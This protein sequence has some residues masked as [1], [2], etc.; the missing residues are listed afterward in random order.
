MNIAVIYSEYYQ[1]VWSGQKK[2]VEDF[3]LEKNLTLEYFKIPGSL[4]APFMAAKIIKQ[5]GFDGIVVLGC[6][7]EGETYHNHIIQNCAHDHL[8]RLSTD[9]LIPMGIGILTVKNYEQALYRSSDKKPYARHAIKA[10][11]DILTK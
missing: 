6:V 3:A 10:V 7:V 5:G 4:E 2:Q 1:E 11:Y 8:I 9:N